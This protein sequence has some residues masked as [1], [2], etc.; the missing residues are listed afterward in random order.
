VV[1]TITFY[2]NGVF[3]VD[4]GDCTPDAC[5]CT[6]D[7]IDVIL[8]LQPFLLFLACQGS[9]CK[10][11]AGST[12]SKYRRVHARCQFAGGRVTLSSNGHHLV[13][14]EPRDM[15]APAN[16]PFMNSISRGECPRELEPGDG[17][18]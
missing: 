4:D 2:A 18:I 15:R 14:G 11:C 7:A 10:L 6:C 9:N 5:L 3:T 16:A 8:Q 12:T 1:H 17:D 13:A